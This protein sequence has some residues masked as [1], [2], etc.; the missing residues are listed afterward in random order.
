M[1][2]YRFCGAVFYPVARLK[3]VDDKLM[4]LASELE[5]RLPSSKLPTTI[6]SDEFTLKLEKNTEPGK[7]LYN[8]LIDN[9]YAGALLFVKE[10]EENTNES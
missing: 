5:D 3:K 10:T 4:D 9:N 2:K 8:I 1:S 7:I 6:E